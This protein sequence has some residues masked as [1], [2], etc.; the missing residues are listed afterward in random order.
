MLFTLIAS[1]IQGQSDK[2]SQRHGSIQKES[3]GS[4]K[5]CTDLSPRI[6]RIWKTE[7]GRRFQALEEEY[8]EGMEVGIALKMA[9]GHSQRC[10]DGLE[11]AV[12]LWRLL[13]GWD[14]IRA[15]A[16]YCGRVGRIAEWQRKWVLKLF[17][18]FQEICR[19]KKQWQWNRGVNSEDNDVIKY[20]LAIFLDMRNKGK[21][22]VQG[23]W[24]LRLTMKWVKLIEKVPQS[25]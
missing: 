14:M 5:E 20:S 22:Y 8:V 13:Q 25:I 15:L 4:Q 2:R 9:H 21:D 23:N 3:Q 18:V 12:N 17:A 7:L 19:F 24:I 1:L 11:V 16:L 10:L 6:C